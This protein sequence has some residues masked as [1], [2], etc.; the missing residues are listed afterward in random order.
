MKRFLSRTLRRSPLVVIVLV[1]V[2]S[3][4]RAGAQVDNGRVKTHPELVDRT[5]GSRVDSAYKLA[6]AH[7]YGAARAAFE[8]LRRDQPQ[9]VAPMVGLGFVDRAEGKRASARAWFRRAL[10]ADP[11][12]TDASTQLALLDWDRPTTITGLIGLVSANGTQ[13]S[14]WSAAASAPVD[15][16]WTLNAGLGQLGAGDPIRGIF[17]DSASGRATFVSGGA[18]FRPRPTTTLAAT[19][20]RWMSSSSGD[21]YL[22]LEAG[23]QVSSVFTIRVGARPV[24]GIGAPQ[25]SIGLDASNGDGGVA[26]LE[27]VQATRQAPFEARSAVRGYYTFT[28]TR[29]DYLRGGVIREFGARNQA[30]TLI[31]TAIHYFVP[32]FGAQLSAADRQGAFARRSVDVGVV[33][34]P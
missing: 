27:F 15:P 33:Y 10:A 19:F 20:T 32:A 1:A 23:Q 11:S 12:Y 26:T 29:R 2:V 22:Y 3:V 21:N 30:T 14:E 8:A 13:T 25:L 18:V 7:R 9:A 17:L 24:Y 16:Q 5:W 34:R 31:A 6:F 4:R 28:P